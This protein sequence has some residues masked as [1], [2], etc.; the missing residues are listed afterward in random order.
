MYVRRPAGERLSD[1]VSDLFD[2]VM[3]G[4]DQVGGLTVNRPSANTLVISRKRTGRLVVMA[5]LVLFPIGLL[6]LLA[7]R[8]ETL[9]IRVDERHDGFEVSALGEGDPAIIGALERFLAEMVGHAGR[10]E[11]A[12]SAVPSGGR[13]GRTI[14]IPSPSRR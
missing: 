10:P 5:C 3:V 12:T 9:T 8:T 11:S 14:A 2:G 6:T 4:V 1:A 13:S 7:R